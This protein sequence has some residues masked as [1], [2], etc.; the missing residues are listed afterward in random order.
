VRRRQNDFDAQSLKRWIRGAI[1]VA[2]ALV[3]CVTHLW[4]L[5]IPVIVFLVV[6]L[7]FGF[8]WTLGDAD[9]PFSMFHSWP[10][11]VAFLLTLVALVLAGVIHMTRSRRGTERYTC[12]AAIIVWF[13]A[14]V[15]SGFGLVYHVSGLFSHSI[16]PQYDSYARGESRNELKQIG[17]ALHNYHDVHHMLPPGGTRSESGEAHHGWATMLLP[18]LDQH[19]LA[20]EIDYHVPWHHAANRK[21]MQTVV[22]AFVHRGLS[23]FRQDARGFGMIHYAAN[24]HVLRMNTTTRFANFTDGKSNTIMAGQ[25][26]SELVPWGQPVNARD[27]LLGLNR[28]PVGFGSPFR[29]IRFGRVSGGCDFMFADGRVKWLNDDV[30]PDVLRALARPS[31]NDAP[32]KDF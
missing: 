16:S 3:L 28:S 24:L 14:A 20:D 15:L 11:G 21:A 30:D 31:D 10:A 7:N 22:P 9:N 8:L 12:R 26:V 1:A 19:A 27:P 2:V 32:D 5:L 17:I 18:Y 13:A 29:H 25:L 4:M 6:Y 23:T